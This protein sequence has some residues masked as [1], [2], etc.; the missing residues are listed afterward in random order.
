MLAA[1]PSEHDLKRA[2]HQQSEMIDQIVRHGARQPAESGK[3]LS[4]MLAHAADL[5]RTGKPVPTA[6]QQ[7]IDSAAHAAS[8]SRSAYI[9]R[10]EAERDQAATQ[11]DEELAHYREVKSAANATGTHVA[12]ARADAQRNNSER[13]REV[14]VEL[15][16]LLAE[17]VLDAQ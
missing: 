7:Q 16:Q 2:Q 13:Q 10:Q 3:K 15:E 9:A 12:A 14:R 4:E 17:H 1:Y 8:K 11:F 5:D 6:L